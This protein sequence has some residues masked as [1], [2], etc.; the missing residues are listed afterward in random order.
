MQCV[1]R[2]LLLSFFSIP[3]ISAALASERSLTAMRQT[4]LQA[5]RYIEQDRD[6][7]FF[8]L[9]DSLIDYPLYPY[10]QYQWLVKHLDETSAIQSYLHDFSA[11]RYAPMLQRKWLSHLGKQQD[12]P[13]FAKYYA[14]SK[15]TELQCYFARAQFHLG[16][17][18][19]AITT[20]KRLWQSGK[21]MP[22]A[23]APL[24]DALVSA[25]DFDNQAAWQRFHAALA[26]NEIE[27]AKQVLPLIPT[28]D[29]ELAATWLNL[30]SNP[31]EITK[32]RKWRQFAEA[33]AI[34]AHAIKRLLKTD[35]QTALAFWDEQKKH[36]PIAETEAAEVEK[37]L[38]MALA[39]N[40]NAE[41]YAR[42][43]PYIGNDGPAQEWLVRAALA[44]QNW[45][46][47]LQAIDRLQPELKHQEKWQYWQAKALQATGKPQQAQTLFQSLAQQRSFYGFLAAGLLQTPIRLNHQ[48]L[49][50]SNR[51]IETLENRNEF[52]AVR[53]WLALERQPEA[54]RQWWHAIDGLE[55]S[56]LTAAAK[57]AQNW[58]WPA[59]AIFTLARANHWDDVEMR[60]PM[61]HQQLIQSNAEQNHLE[62][63]LLFGLIRQE[64]AF[65]PLAGSG[66]GAIGLMQ[67]MPATAK[68]MAGELKE[69]WNNQYNL[70][71]PDTNIRYGSRYYKKILD[72]FNGHLILATAAYNAGPN[73]VK[74]WLP[75]SS[76]LPADIWLETVPY[77]ETRSYIASV[78]M[79]AL[80]YQERLQKNRLKVADLL[81]PVLPG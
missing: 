47:V 74:Q 77:K 28:K 46:E 18:S 33:G 40:R 57:L 9:A 35:P 7:D 12:W 58:Q 80:I 2:P 30:H 41:A 11:S 60:F 73:R 10:I 56:Q 31:L 29:W 54:I 75:Q 39:F 44:Q 71:N 42:L 24:F 38:G 59:M 20:A 70:L 43:A 45:P 26:Q 27:V 61:P 8:A 51:Q 66:A 68:Q 15:D 16:Q 1:F 21:T 64:S 37:Q 50:V 3:F 62:A 69:P 19:A 5:E 6:L 63:S 52:Q 14:P 34:L 25:S 4:F 13:A 79:Y 36:F 22:A 32:D 65:D 76:P 67:L 49:Q 55:S 23:C 81:Q 72:R 53:E 78:L 48:P 17:E